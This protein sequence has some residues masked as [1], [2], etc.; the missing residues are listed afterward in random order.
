MGQFKYFIFILILFTIT[1]FS[2]VNW[3]LYVLE[4]DISPLEQQNSNA[5][6]EAEVLEP[7]Q[8]SYQKKPIALYQ[9]IIARP[10]FRQSRQP[11]KKR[12]V[13]VQK[14]KVVK[15]PPPP[16]RAITMNLELLGVMLQNN[17]QAAL[18]RSPSKPNGIWKKA[19]DV[20]EG[21]KIRSI[22]AE[23][24]II[25]NTGKKNEIRLYDLKTKKRTN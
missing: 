4:I 5:K 10:V 18:I 7:T 12:P 22:T 17:N 13:N 3:R 16:V 15:P 2:Y 8:L 24:V 20:M 19:G 1:G 23:Q 6:K 11:V 9:E 21:W 14:R 25:E